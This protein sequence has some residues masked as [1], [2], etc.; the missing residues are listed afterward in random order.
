MPA[1]ESAT[2]ERSSQ[3]QLFLSLPALAETVSRRRASGAAGT[4][5]H[6]RRWFSRQ[7]FPATGPHQLG[8]RMKSQW[9]WTR[10]LVR[11]M[12]RTDGA[13]F[14]LHDETYASKRVSANREIPIQQ[15]GITAP[16]PFSQGRNHRSGEPLSPSMP[17]FAMIGTITR[18]ATGSAHHQPSSQLSARPTS[19]IAERYM[20]KSVWR[21]SASIAALFSLAA[22]RLFARA[23]SGITTS[24]T[25]AITT[26]KTLRSGTSRA[27]RVLIE[28]TAM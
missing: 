19:R 28:S 3:V 20:Q 10:Q 4:P 1:P 2:P 13:W 24:D 26:P 9:Y 27:S 16:P 14:L 5:P 18:A 25:T 6:W 8:G 11:S 23:R 22:T 15:N 7:T 12:G 21:E 17:S